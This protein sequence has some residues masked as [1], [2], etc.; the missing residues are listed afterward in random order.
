MMST[1]HEQI[2]QRGFDAFETAD[3]D[4][5][6]ADWAPDVVWDLTYHQTWPGDA[7]RYVGHGQILAAFATYLSGAE[8][9]RLEI[10]ELRELEDGRV[11][12]LY[13]EWRRD[14]GETEAK[15]IEMA[16]IHTIED[17]QVRHMQ[18]HTSHDSARRVAGVQ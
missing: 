8:T 3:M 15:P 16:I 12:V 18:V 10:H 2:V 4:A 9:Q 17:G 11:L 5:F 7:D 14:P 1:E 6:T 13:T